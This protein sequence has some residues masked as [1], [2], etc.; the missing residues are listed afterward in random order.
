MRTNAD[1]LQHRIQLF[2]A[3]DRIRFYSLVH[4]KEITH[5]AGVSWNETSSGTRQK[6]IARRMPRGLFG[7]IGLMTVRSWLVSSQRMIRDSGVEA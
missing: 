4:G 7:S 6:H 2:L 5:P 3:Q 1:E